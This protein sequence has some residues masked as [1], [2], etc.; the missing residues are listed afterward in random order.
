MKSKSRNTLSFRILRIT[1]I[2]SLFFVSGCDQLSKLTDGT[3]FR[4]TDLLEAV[5][6]SGELIVLTRNAPTTYYEGRDGPD[7]YEYQLVELLA[8]SLNVRTSYKILNSVDEILVAVKNGQGH[9]GAA[10]ITRTNEREKTYSFGPDYRHIEQQ[11]VCHR[12]GPAPKNKEDLED[13]SILLVHGTSYV[14]NMERLKVDI[15]GLVWNTT[16]ELSTEQVLEKVW[17]REVDCTLADSN[18]IAINQR[19]YP[20]LKV[21]F[22]AS[23]TQSLAWVLPDNS[24][25]FQKELAKWFEEIKANNVLAEME[26]RYYGHT[27]IFDYVDIRAYKRRII[28]RLPKYRQLFHTAAKKYNIPWTTL[29]AQS[30]QESH[31]DAMAKSPTGVRGMMMLTQKTAESLGVTSRLD[32]Q[33]SINGGARYLAQLLKRIP[34]DVQKEDKLWFALAAYNVGMG[35]LWD[36]RTLA[37]QLG[38]NPGKWVDIQAVFPHLSQKKF[39]KNLKYGYARGTEPVRYVTRV[40]NYQDILEKELSLTKELA[41]YGEKEK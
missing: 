6:K 34:E 22:P 8:K 24:G 36:A 26:E 28:D 14:E 9:I 23:E 1:I 39:Y 18:I 5:Q 15:P 19:Y 13:L 16:R 35:H 38:K 31:W 40:R 4:K 27:E 3:I 10:G 33:E 37:R 17:R 2:I 29:S 12:L 11:I 30:Y 32:P 41:E 21:A 20:E 25:K 7:G